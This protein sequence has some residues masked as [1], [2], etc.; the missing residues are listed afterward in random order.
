CHLRTLA[1]M[2]RPDLAVAVEKFLWGLTDDGTSPANAHR[3]GR[4]T[5]Q[6][7]R[8]LWRKKRVLDADPLA[9]IDLPKSENADGRRRALTEAEL[10][11]LYAATE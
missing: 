7:T 2:H 10:V 8:W 6:F 1:D 4:Q 3:V 9:A 5:R 11:A